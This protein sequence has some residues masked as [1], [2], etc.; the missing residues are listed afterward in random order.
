MT[1]PKNSVLGVKSEIII[2][3]LKDGDMSKFE[4]AEGRCIL[5]GCIFEIDNL[6]GKTVGIERIYIEE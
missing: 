5:N 2:N 4:T 1:G 3:R 6:T